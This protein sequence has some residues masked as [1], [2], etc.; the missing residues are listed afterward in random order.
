MNEMSVSF[1]KSRLIFVLAM[2]FCLSWN[3]FAADKNVKP[4]WI[5][6][7]PE[8]GDYIY[9]VGIGDGGKIEDAREVA[10]QNARKE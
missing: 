4:D 10:L 7:L 1:I 8:S 9:A 3:V 6:E 5:I 2:I